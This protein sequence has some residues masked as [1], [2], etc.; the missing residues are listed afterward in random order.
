MAT[1][2]VQRNVG[3]IDPNRRQNALAHIRYASIISDGHESAT[4]LSTAEEDHEG[5]MPQDY[6]P[7][8]PASAIGVSIGHEQTR[9]TSPQTPAAEKAAA[10]ED[11]EGG[12]LFDD[13]IPVT[14]PEEGKEYG[15]Q[16]SAASDVKQQ[17]QLALATGEVVHEQDTAAVSPPTMPSPWRSMP[18]EFTKRSEESR[19]SMMESFTR[20][21]SSSGPSAVE[22]LK[23]YMPSISMPSMPKSPSM[24]NFSFSNFSPTTSSTRTAQDTLNQTSQPGHAA[25]ST[26][27][28]LSM[29]ASPSSV[30][31]PP[32]RRST[33]ASPLQTPIA[34]EPASQLSYSDGARDDLSI[35]RTADSDKRIAADISRQSTRHSLRRSTSDDSLLLHRGL[36]RAPSLGDDT[37][38]ESVQEQVNSRLKAIKDSWADA[39]FRVPGMPSARTFSLDKLRHELAQARMEFTAKR[40]TSPAKREHSRSFS[41]DKLHRTSATPRESLTRSAQPS[42][43]GTD[44][45]AKTAEQHP[46]FTRALSELTG[47]L[48]VLGGYRGSILRSAEPPHRQLWVPLK[49]GLNLRKV[50]LEVGFDP[51]D[52]ETMEKRVIPGGM[53]THIGPVDI[54]KR[55][56]KRLRHCEN[57][58]NGKLRIHE[59]GYDWRLSP[60]LLSRKLKTFL[61]GL[62]CNKPRT[63][64]N[65]QGAFV[66]AH[67]LG[68][69]VAR[70]VINTSPSLVAGVVY[71]GTPNNCVNILGPLRN[72][73]DVLLSS[74]VLTAQVNFSIRT[75][76]ALLPLD[77]KCFINKTT[78]E[79]YPVDFF[80]PQQWVEY[81]WSPC[82]NRPL[83]PL[84]EAPPGGIT[85]LVNSVTS[86]LPS[87][88]IP[89]RKGSVSR[90]DTVQN[91]SNRNG[92]SSNNSATSPTRSGQNAGTEATAQV[93]GMDPQMS[94]H[95]HAG[96]T[97]TSHNASVGTT[98]TISKERALEYL[99]RTL[100]EVKRFKQE[101]AFQ[102]AIGSTNTYPPSAVIYGKSIPTVYG[103]KVVSREAIKHADAYDELAFA[104]G[105]G[106]VLAKGAQLKDGWEATLARGGVVSSD[107]G[108]VTLLGDLEAVGKCLVAVMRSRERGVGLGL[109]GRKGSADRKERGKSVAV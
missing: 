108:H 97:S 40:S 82:I 105:D 102:P 25:S 89:G 75:S 79:E 52:E 83:P 12:G 57:A 7:H 27:T 101:L 60:H 4:D 36:S 84:K 53:L 43:A 35:G 8:N 81:R 68:G 48:V 9:L 32:V 37:R 64:P 76:F 107:R 47:D 28:G 20:R 3:P 56:L 49:V 41:G 44:M 80:D 72:G 15:I 39:N 30:M 29:R 91:T 90:S 100:S 24:L 67:S 77:G 104:S 10:M 14:P 18:R 17:P 19:M 1:P 95:V 98:V 88:P 92:S 16:E 65:K 45:A 85:G 103:A 93:A 99:T 26:S 73:D 11:I 71:A 96:D 63:P 74:R 109:E 87:L 86:A 62:P 13:A 59:W 54:A 42:A 66:L 5:P 23:K 22:S 46:N 21:R 69:L 6:P 70:H 50:D 2:T 31:S 94:S 33:I 78:K 51:E 55:L 38:F 61:E 106:V 58:K 34:E